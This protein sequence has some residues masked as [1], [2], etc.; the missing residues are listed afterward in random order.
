MNE[1]YGQCR[2][3]ELINMTCLKNAVSRKVSARLFDN[4]NS[5]IKKKTSFRLYHRQSHRLHH[6]RAQTEP[7]TCTP[8]TSPAPCWRACHPPVKVT[9][10]HPR[11]YFQELEA[12]G[13][14]PNQS[15]ASA[16][17][18]ITSRPHRAS[19]VRDRRSGKSGRKLRDAQQAQ[20]SER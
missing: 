19:E 13:R 1:K 8:A 14:P 17:L 18:R 5:K 7:N 4:Q 2:A 3:N 10:V 6:S 9:E 16:A 11:V 12:R 15:E 20:R